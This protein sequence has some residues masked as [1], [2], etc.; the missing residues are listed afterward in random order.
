[1][2]VHCVGLDLPQVFTVFDEYKVSA[3]YVIP[4]LT[5]AELKLAMPYKFANVTL[6]YPDK[7]P[8]IQ[9]VSDL[10]KAWHAGLSNFADFNN[11][12]ECKNGINPSSIGIEFHTPGY[13]DGG[14]DWYKFTPFTKG[15]QET[16]IKL[17]QHLMDDFHINHHNLLAHST[18]SVGRK[19]DPGPLFFFKELQQANLGYM[20]TPKASVH[21]ATEDSTVQFIQQKLLAIGFNKCPQTGA[22]DDPTQDHIDAFI[23]QFTPHIWQ[24]KH[25]PVSQ[26]LIEHLEGFEPCVIG[27]NN[28]CLMKV[29][30]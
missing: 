30:L 25:T 28:D 11:V 15:Q 23:M 24:G 7:V 17:I 9:L 27:V 18:I 21:S 6:N 8:V 1:M 12:A 22:L 29:E 2:V 4:Q 14:N 5:G 19:T 26:E 13:G 16:G 3:H 10:D 20:P